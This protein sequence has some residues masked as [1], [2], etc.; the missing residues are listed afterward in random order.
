MLPLYISKM[1]NHLGRLNRNRFKYNVPSIQD[2]YSNISALDNA[3]IHN[4]NS[5]IPED[6]MVLEE[7]SIDENFIFYPEKILYVF[8]FLT[9]KNYLERK[10]RK[11]GKIFGKN[12]HFAW[13]YIVNIYSWQDNKFLYYN[14]ISTVMDNFLLFFNSIQLKNIK[15]SI[16]NIKIDNQSNNHFLNLIRFFKLNFSSDQIK[17]CLTIENILK[18]EDFL[19]HFVFFYIKKR[20]YCRDLLKIFK[21]S[22]SPRI[23]NEKANMILCL[24]GLFF[25]EF[26]RKEKKNSLSRYISFAEKAESIESKNFN[27]FL[28]LVYECNIDFFHQNT[29]YILFEIREKIIENLIENMNLKPTQQLNYKFERLIYDSNK[30]KKRTIYKTKKNF[31]DILKENLAHLIYRMYL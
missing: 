20:H 16:P 21:I 11:V 18:V 12:F 28:D 15:K 9:L 31:Y 1:Q 26:L 23:K 4:E 13:K 22:L 24:L 7:K 27:R 30:K 5:I 17:L 2:F 6:F 10:L 14:S 19:V 29:K 25:I 8:D 3:R